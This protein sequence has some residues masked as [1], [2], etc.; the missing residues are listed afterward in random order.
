MHIMRCCIMSYFFIP[1]ILQEDH[2]N[3][4]NLRE[5]SGSSLSFLPE[6][7]QAEPYRADVRTESFLP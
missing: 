4:F 1:M 2:R 7:C 6:E 5:I 3:I